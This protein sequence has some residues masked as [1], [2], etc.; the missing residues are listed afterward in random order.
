MEKYNVYTIDINSKTKLV[1][2]N[3]SRGLA[4]IR[5][6][7][8]QKSIHNNLVADI[9]DISE[10]NKDVFDYSDSEEQMFFN[11]DVQCDDKFLDY[12]EMVEVNSSED[13][14]YKSNLK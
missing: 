12:V 5:M 6:K 10:F 3:L 14:K 11:G 13:L 4:L 1:G 8:T 7:N 9:K 2:E